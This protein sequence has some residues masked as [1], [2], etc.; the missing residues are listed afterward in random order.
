MLFLF[1]FL[2]GDVYPVRVHEGGETVVAQGM[3]G[4]S[5]ETSLRS[6]RLRHRHQGSLLL[7]QGEQLFRLLLFL[8]KGTQLLLIAITLI[9]RGTFLFFFFLILA[10][11]SPR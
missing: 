6:C 11:F 7:H 1:Y 5:T 4:D 2:S 8:Y 9:H 3:P 10:S